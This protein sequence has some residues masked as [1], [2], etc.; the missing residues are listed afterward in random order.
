ML[1]PRSFFSLPPS[2]CSTVVGL[3]LLGQQTLPVVS[4]STSDNTLTLN[5]SLSLNTSTLTSST[6]PLPASN[7]STSRRRTISVAL[8]NAQDSSS[9][10]RFF[11]TNNTAVSDPGPSSAQ[12]DVYELIIQSDGIANVSLTFDGVNEIDSPGVVAVDAGTSSQAFE[13]GM[14]DTEGAHASQ[15]LMQRIIILAVNRTTA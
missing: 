1:S 12:P 3:L 8:C 2:L 7:G 14:T 9:R 5:E 4:Q 15:A 11:A 13:L 6:F 10:T